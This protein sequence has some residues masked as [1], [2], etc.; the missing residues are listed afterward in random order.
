MRGLEWGRLYETYHNTSYDP[1]RLEAEIRRLMGDPAVQS[2]KGIYEYLLGGEEHPE[3]L[4][5]RLFDDRTKK[6]AF[7]RQTVKAVERQVIPHSEA[8]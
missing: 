8:L 5:I 3:L 4:S 1:G 6:L 2:R 7:E